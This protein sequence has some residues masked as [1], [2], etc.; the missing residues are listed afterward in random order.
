M[1]RRR[2]PLSPPP[3]RCRTA[4]HGGRHAARRGAR[5]DYSGGGGGD[6]GDL[7]PPHRRRP[8]RWCDCAGGAALHT[9]A[10][11]RGRCGSFNIAAIDHSRGRQRGSTGWAKGESERSLKGHASPATSP[12][13]AAMLRTR[14]GGAEPRAVARRRPGDFPLPP[15]RWA[16]PVALP[17]HRHS[18]RSC[19]SHRLPHQRRGRAPGSQTTAMGLPHR[20]RRNHH[21]Q[22]PRRTAPPASRPGPCSPPYPTTSGEWRMGAIATTTAAATDGTPAAPPPR[23]SPV[24][25]RRL[26]RTT[27]YAGSVLVIGRSSEPSMLQVALCILG[28]Y[29]IFPCT[30]RSTCPLCCV[31]WVRQRCCACA[32]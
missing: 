2:R 13:T 31:C 16:P 8:R 24:T 1:A 23:R 10:G 29:T 17:C 14:R 20:Y 30:P 28:S 26:R 18:R 6:G 27:L 21:H 4:G 12:S 15:P 5:E 11:G 32:R 19:Q 25:A 7:Y 22:T 3:R 9:C